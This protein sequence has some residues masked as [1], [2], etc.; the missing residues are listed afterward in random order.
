MLPVCATARAA[1]W[2]AG[3][4]AGCTGA[5]TREQW[6]R[7]LRGPSP[8]GGVHRY[9]AASLG[10]AADVSRETA[11]ARGRVGCWAGVGERQWVSGGSA[12]ARDCRR[13]MLAPGATR[14][15]RR[16]LLDADG[17]LPWEQD[18][19]PTRAAFPSS[20][21][22]PGGAGPHSCVI[23][24]IEVDE[25]GRRDGGLRGRVTCADGLSGRRRER[26]AKLRESALRTHG[27]SGAGDTRKRAHVSRETVG[28]SASDS[29][30]LRLYPAAG[31]RMDGVA[32]WVPAR[33]PRVGRG[34]G[35]TG[36]CV[37]RFRTFDRATAERAGHRRRDT[38]QSLRLREARTARRPRRVRSEPASAP[39]PVARTGVPCQRATPAASD[40]RRAP[41]TGQP[42]NQADRSISS[43][44]SGP[45]PTADTCGWP[46]IPA[47]GTP[48]SH[49]PLGGRHSRCRSAWR[50]PLCRAH[51]RAA[52]VRL[53]S[54][55][56]A[57]GH[58]GRRCPRFP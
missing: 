55:G 27:I 44:R 9:S 57:G 47:G 51:C 19:S 38:G 53:A 12:A 56:G 11:S 6:A 16:R 23:C 49:G 31:Y 54:G 3:I 20:C 45:R 15:Q 21:R 5:P 18:A 7:V 8:N 40:G 24:P 43:D 14:R 28:G 32:P 33:T 58:R 29:C 48:I 25:R 10:T 52:S 13:R 26:R 39:H 34:C 4:R 30:V 50:I 1:K 36:E 37:I 42:C 17:S 41:S 22:V 2:G 35:W 46:S